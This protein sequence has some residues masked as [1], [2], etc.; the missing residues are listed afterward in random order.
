[1]RRKSYW[2]RWFGPQWP[3][4]LSGLLRENH[5]AFGQLRCFA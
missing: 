4:A 2:T 1:M 3:E 5:L